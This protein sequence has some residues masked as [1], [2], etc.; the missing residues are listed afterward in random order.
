VDL[1]FIAQYLMLKHASARPE[2]LR[3]NLWDAF[4]ALHRAGIL[5]GEHRQELVEAYGFLRTVEGRLRLIHNRASADVPTRTAELIGLTRRLNY[6]DP[7][8]DEAVRAFLADVARQTMRTRSL[9]EE[10]VGP[11]QRAE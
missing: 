2:L 8:P 7:D 1:E 4:D 11:L 3:P 5:T 6:M 9:L 10:Y